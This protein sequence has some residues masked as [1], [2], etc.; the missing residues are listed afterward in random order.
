MQQ[1]TNNEPQPRF[2]AQAQ[3][4][5]GRRLN[6]DSGPPELAG[7]PRD[8]EAEVRSKQG[9]RGSIEDMTEEEGGWVA[10]VGLATQ[11]EAGGRGGGW[12][13]GGDAGST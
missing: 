9:I 7:E 5:K 6:A 13:G 8:G 12:G 3:S 4:P 1:E 11:H 2:N 10:A